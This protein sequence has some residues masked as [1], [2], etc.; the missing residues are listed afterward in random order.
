MLNRGCDNGQGIQLEAPTKVR[1][2]KKCDYF[3]LNTN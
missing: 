3:K 2:Y 1:F